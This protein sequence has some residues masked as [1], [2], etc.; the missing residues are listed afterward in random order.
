MVTGDLQLVMWKHIGNEL[1]ELQAQQ[2]HVVKFE[3]M[4]LLL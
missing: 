1:L 2:V 3:E 4:E